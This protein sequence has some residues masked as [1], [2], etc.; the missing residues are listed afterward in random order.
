M[1][2]NL[3]KGDDIKFFG[4]VL[5]NKL[6]NG[7]GKYRFQTASFPG[8]TSGTGVELGTGGDVAGLAGGK[9]KIPGAAADVQ[10]APRARR[11]W[12]T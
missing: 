4:G 12:V 2:K 7:K 8:K 9:K 3:E 5:L 11:I 6:L 1:L 10:E